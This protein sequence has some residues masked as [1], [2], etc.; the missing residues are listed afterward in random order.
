MVSLVKGEINKSNW[1]FVLTSNPP[2]YLINHHL[3][4]VKLMV[5]DG[6]LFTAGST[7]T[8]GLHVQLISSRFIS[9]AVTVDVGK[10]PPGKVSKCESCARLGLGQLGSW[11]LG[12]LGWQCLPSRGL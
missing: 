5:S 9:K 3:F 12:F 8:Y 6:G 10:S 11:E 1:K 4:V 7:A 2:R